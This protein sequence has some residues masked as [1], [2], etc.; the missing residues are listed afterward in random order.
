MINQIPSP[1]DTQTARLKA[2]GASPIHVYSYQPALGTALTPLGEPNTA[3]TY[4]VMAIP[5]LL[6]SSSASDTAVSVLIT[7]FEANFDLTTDT[8]RREDGSSMADAHRELHG[9]CIPHGGRVSDRKHR[10]VRI[11]TC[12]W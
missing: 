12:H 9:G 8:L 1:L 2:P 7:G 4:P 6:Y 11:V 3:Y 5:M 10:T